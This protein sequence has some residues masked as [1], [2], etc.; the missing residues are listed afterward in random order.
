MPKLIKPIE[1]PGIRAVEKDIDL[2]KEKFCEESIIA[3]RNADITFEEQNELFGLLANHLGFNVGNEYSENHSRVKDHMT[4]DDYML[5]WHVEHAYWDNPVCAASWYM[6]T[7]KE[8]PQNGRT[9]FYPM[10]KMF[11]EL[12]PEW[13]ELALNSYIEAIDNKE[14]NQPLFDLFWRDEWEDGDTYITNRPIAVEHFITKSPVMRV[15]NLGSRPERYDHL[16]KINNI[17]GRIPTEEEQKMYLEMH[18]YIV[19]KINTPINKTDDSHIIHEWREKDILI[20]DLYTMAH[21][22]LGGFDSSKRDFRGLWGRIENH[23]TYKNK[24]PL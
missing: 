5:I 21:T 18:H 14:E 19:N 9:A 10:H 20:P 23:L 8:D 7:F 2:Y 6:H 11:D 12:K 13:Q 1:Y 24:M 16:H 22:V 15:A 3:F 17:N 4:K